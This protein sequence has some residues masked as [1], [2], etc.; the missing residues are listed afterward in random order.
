MHSYLLCLLVN[1]YG[2][3]RSYRFQVG[4]GGGGRGVVQNREM[5]LL[6]L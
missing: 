5:C 1:T 4:G 6:V 3:W 2:A